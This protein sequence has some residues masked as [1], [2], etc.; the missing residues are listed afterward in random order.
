M[1]PANVAPAGHQTNWR[2]CN[3]CDGLAYGGGTGACP[4]GAST[5]TLA[6]VTMRSQ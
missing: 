4:A 2:W 6:P 5:T 3:K 1:L